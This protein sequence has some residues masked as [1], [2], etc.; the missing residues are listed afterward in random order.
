MLLL[1]VTYCSYLCEGSAILRRNMKAKKEQ[2]EEL[3]NAMDLVGFENDVC[4]K[5]IIEACLMFYYSLLS[6]KRTC[7]FVWQL[8]LTWATLSL[9]KMRMSIRLLKTRQQLW[10]L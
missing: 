10:P 4:Y 7:S 1:C 2:F 3:Q 8:S 6:I 5:N 9:E